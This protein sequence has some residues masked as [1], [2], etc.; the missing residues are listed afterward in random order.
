MATLAPLPPGS[1]L[2]VKCQYECE[3]GFLTTNLEEAE[4]R[5]E[6]VSLLGSFINEGHVN[7]GA[8]K[9]LCV[10]LLKKWEKYEPAFNRV[11]ALMQKQKDRAN[12][13]KKKAA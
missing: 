7:E 5:N 4:R 1:K 11:R 2:K 3:D 12:R 8:L 9:N 10:D 6:A 13:L